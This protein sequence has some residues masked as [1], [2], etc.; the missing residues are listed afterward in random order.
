MF[1]VCFSPAA[2]AA[3]RLRGHTHT[4]HAGLSTGPRP[5]G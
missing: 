4:L 1:A 5:A 3:A 2:A